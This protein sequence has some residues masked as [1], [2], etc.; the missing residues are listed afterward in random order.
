MDL[1]RKPNSKYFWYDFTVRGERFCGSTKETN[2]TRADKVVALKLA[3]AI[4][5]SDPLDRK[6]P[7]LRDYSKDFLEWVDTGRLEPDSRRYYKNG[8]RLLRV[9]KIAGKRIGAASSPLTC[10]LGQRPAPLLTSYTEIAKGS[11]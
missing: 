1:F 11:P 2:E 3:A 8:G 9:T 5:G 10:S 6:P 4:K 7:S